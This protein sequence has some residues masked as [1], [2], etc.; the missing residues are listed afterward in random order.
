[1]AIEQLASATAQ[2]IGAL[3]T[4]IQSISK[5][6]SSATSVEAASAASNLSITAGEGQNS[7]KLVLKSAIEGINASLEPTIGTDAIQAARDSGIGANSLATP[8]NP[9]ETAS[10]IVASSAELFEAYEAVDPDEDPLEALMQFTETI[11]SGFDQGFDE[12]IAFY[13]A[14][15]PQRQLDENVKPTIEATREIVSEKLN[16]FMESATI[17]KSGVINPDSTAAAQ[18]GKAQQII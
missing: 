9:E 4:P 6:A 3:S 16:A 18:S 15:D 12:A 11:R 13:N 10:Q 5:A 17:Q 7:L 14:L 2:N 8:S 1:M